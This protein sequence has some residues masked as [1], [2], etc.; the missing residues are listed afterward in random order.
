M[1]SS[2]SQGGGWVRTNG[3]AWRP[4]SHTG[5]AQSRVGTKVSPFCKYLRSKAAFQ[6]YFWIAQSQQKWLLTCPKTVNHT[7]SSHSKSNHHYD[8]FLKTIFFKR[9]YYRNESLSLDRI[10]VCQI[11]PFITTF[12]EYIFLFVWLSLNN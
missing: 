7:N 2:G 11:D 5:A 4:L 6:K 9:K 8:T 10:K 1:K 12:F 3:V